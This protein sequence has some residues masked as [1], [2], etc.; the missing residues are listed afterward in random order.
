MINK[1]R[2]HSYHLLRWTERYTK[3][4]MVYFASGNFWLSFKK[5]LSAGIAFGL[6]LAFANFVSPELYGK[7][8]YFFSIFAILTIPTLPGMGQAV[9]RA[10]A[11]G[12]EGTIFQ[13]LRMK[14]LWGT[15]G[16][17]A[18]LS[19]AIYYFFNSQPEL[20]IS[21]FL[22]S[23]FLPFVDTLG[24]FNSILTGKKLFK[25]S[26]FYE[27]GVQATAA[28]LIALTIF[29]TRNLA[30]ILLAYFVSYTLT[31]F[32]AFQL[33]YKRYL[34]ND[35]QDPKTLTYGSHL[36]FLSVV[37]TIV[38]TLDNILLWNFTGAAA[39]ATFAFAKAFPN[40]IQ[41]ILENIPT[42]AFPK[43]A[44]KSFGEIRQTLSQKIIKI[45]FGLIVIIIVY[46]F[47]APYIFKIFFPQYLNAIFYSQIFALSLLFFPKKI[48]GT[49]FG[50][51]AHTKKLYAY[52]F[53][54]SIV[55]LTLTLALTP[56]Y[57]IMGAI[58]SELGSRLFSLVFMLFL[59]IKAK[60]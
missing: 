30:L 9:S 34:D 4:D 50:A 24:I 1:L 17:I 52:T 57:G 40:Q 13:V 15:I 37:S 28:I 22:A 3:T 33:V 19:V 55:K 12:F 23:F 58:L 43:F 21:F 32:I 54:S 16:G 45:F 36:S 48:L 2:N 18:S 6:S 35:K 46:F 29:I 26:I 49:V 38:D 53:S 10:I 39:I 14:I 51:Q 27:I 8:K 56:T 5:I 42:L 20:A 47:I 41:L 59:F 31:R 11:R 44:Q 25:I 60:A 7:Y